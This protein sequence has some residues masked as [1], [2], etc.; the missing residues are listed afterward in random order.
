[1][2]CLLTKILIHCLCNDCMAVEL[3]MNSHITSSDA[4]ETIFRYY[5]LGRNV[6]SFKMVRVVFC[7]VLNAQKYFSFLSVLSLYWC[8]SNS[9]LGFDSGQ[10]SCGNQVLCNSEICNT[11]HVIKLTCMQINFKNCRGINADCFWMGYIMRVTEMLLIL[12]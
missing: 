2:G 5:L 8:T 9:N 7:F 11:N 6:N 1:M 3:S 10:I 12:D 4:R